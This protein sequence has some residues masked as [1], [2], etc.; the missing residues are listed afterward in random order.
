MPEIKILDTPEEL[1][2]NKKSWS[3]RFLIAGGGLV[4]LVFIIAI[5]WAV[6]GLI[7]DDEEGMVLGLGIL[8]GFG[9]NIAGFILGIIEQTRK[10]KWALLG[11]LGN[12]GFI[13]FFVLIM[14]VGIS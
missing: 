6:I 5:Y 2:S 3:I 8:I 10:Q 7:E 9:L 14:F 13:L 12:L 1:H 11:L 4:S